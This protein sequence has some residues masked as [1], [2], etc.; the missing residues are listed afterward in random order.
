MPTKS[1]A[2]KKPSRPIRTAL[3]TCHDCGAK[4]CHDLV[5]PIEKPKTADDIF[6][7]KW[8]LQYHTVAVFVRSYRWYRIIRGPC[9]Y[10]DSHD[11]CTIYERRPSRCRAMKPPEC[12]HFG[13][14]WDVIIETPEDLDAH[15]ANGKRRK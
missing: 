3:D 8:E 12:E 14:F 1:N 13:K 6:E 11:R 4:C 15:L 7:L 2:Q 10:L 9:Q 5:M